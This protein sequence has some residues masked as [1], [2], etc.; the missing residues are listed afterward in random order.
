MTV[1][2]CQFADPDKPRQD[3]FLGVAV[4]ELDEAHGRVSVMDVARECQRRGCNPGGAFK[5]TELPGE[6]ALR[7]G[8]EN[9][10][11]LMT[12]DAL[13]MTLGSVGR[14]KANMS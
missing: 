7:I 12:D 5:V 9:R 4:V 10:N 1:F 6:A 3:Q 11:R 2:W 14:N 8:P 13:L